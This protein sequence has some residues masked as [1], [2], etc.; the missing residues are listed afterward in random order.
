MLPKQFEFLNKEGA[1]KML[2][3]ALKLYGVTEKAGSSDNPTI[4]AWA[5]ELGIKD[6]TADSIPWCGLF[7]AI[8]AKRA[9]KTVVDQPLW[10]RN[11]SNF[12]KK[13]DIAMLGDVLVFKRSNGAGHVGLY[14]GETKT[15]YYVLGGNQGDKV[16][17]VPILKSRLISINAE[18]KTA[19]PANVRQI[20]FKED[21]KPV[22]NNEQ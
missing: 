1:P 11:W 3:E 22:S 16:S 18:Y 4:L 21:G 2:L 13:R 12:G 14:A 6:Y 7:I 8:I 15:K 9:D 20:F 19:Q 10:A 17:I 5:R